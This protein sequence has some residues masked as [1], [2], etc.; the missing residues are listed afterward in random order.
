M[1]KLNE[2]GDILKTQN[3]FKYT[4]LAFEDEHIEVSNKEYVKRTVFKKCARDSFYSF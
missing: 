1:L 2:G 4:K 3:Y